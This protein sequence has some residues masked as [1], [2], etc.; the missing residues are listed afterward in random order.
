MFPFY[1][2]PKFF[3]KI[4]GLALRGVALHGRYGTLFQTLAPP[5]RGASC[6]NV[7]P[8]N[9]ASGFAL[10]DDQGLGVPSPT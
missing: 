9:N 3:S 2:N 4:M 5:T 1:G 7:A 10:R 6:V 8:L